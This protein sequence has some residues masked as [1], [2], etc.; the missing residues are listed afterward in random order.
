MLSVPQRNEYIRDDL[1][2]NLVKIGWDF[3]FKKGITLT[4]SFFLRSLSL[5]QNRVL[6]HK[7]YPINVC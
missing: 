2:V 6:A 5:W 7:K 1:S 3:P 4:K